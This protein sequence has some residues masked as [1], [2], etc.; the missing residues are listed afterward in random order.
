MS[1]DWSVGLFGCCHDCGMCIDH[2]CC[3]P[4]QI[5]RQLN[6]LNGER[7]TCD[8]PMCALNCLCAPVAWACIFNIRRK[9]VDKYHIDE[10]MIASVLK[11]CCCPACNL[12]QTHTELTV[13][14]TWPG[15]TCCGKQPSAPPN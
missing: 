4:C 9:V 15:G 13:R 12:C 5:S 6:A 7:D 2:I 3:E 10:N 1:S 11:C 14:G 8:I